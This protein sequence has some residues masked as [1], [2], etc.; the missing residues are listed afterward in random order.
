MKKIKTW[1]LICFSLLLIFSCASN[2]STTGKV[3]VEAKNELKFESIIK[4]VKESIV[5]M[6]MSVDETTTEESNKNSICTGIIINELGHIV[7]NFHCIYKNDYIR[8]YYYDKKDWREHKV[9]IIGTDPLADLALITIS[10]KK[11]PFSYLKIADDAGDIKE[12]TE[13]FAVGH[14]M[15]MTWTITKGIVSSVERYARHPYIKAIQTDASIN[16]GNSGGPLLNMKGEIVG[17]NALI[18]SKVKESAGVALSIRGDIIKKSIDIMMTSKSVDRPAI[19]VMIMQLVGEKR[20]QKILNGND[21]ITVTIPN[22]FGLLIRPDKNLPKALE[23]WDTLV[24]I[25]GAPINDGLELAEELI[26]YNIG[27]E[28]TLTIIRDGKHILI[29]IPL[30]VFPVPIEEMYKKT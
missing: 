23:P 11:G 4:K 14:P 21:N 24:G 13:V 7:T 1:F 20:R 27:E 29:K 9:T 22:T 2:I 26:K 19:G 6:T 8:V 10:D 15:G 25:N 16:Q 3:L 18:I 28:I 12:G 5:L 17:I 30:K